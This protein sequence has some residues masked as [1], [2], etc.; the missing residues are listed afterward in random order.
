MWDSTSQD[1][2]RAPPG[3]ADADFNLKPPS[4]PELADSE[5]G[6]IRV[7][8]HP[9]IDVGAGPPRLAHLAHRDA[10]HDSAA[11]RG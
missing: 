9:G 8:G 6:R 4:H 10:F 2:T 3:R 7:R 5:I 11:I 1:E